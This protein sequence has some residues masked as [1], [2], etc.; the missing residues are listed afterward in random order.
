MNIID[1]IIMSIN[2]NDNYN[3]YTTI[4]GNDHELGNQMDKFY[5]PESASVTIN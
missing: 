3:E 2:Y 1:I 5:M 4:S